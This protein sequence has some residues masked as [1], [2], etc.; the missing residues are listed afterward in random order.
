MN[1]QHVE[2]GFHYSAKELKAVATKI[3]KLATYCNKVKDESSYIRVDAEN[4]KTE[5]KRDAMKVAMTIKLPSKILRA[6]SRRPE[7][8]EAIDRCVEKLTTQVKKY[9]ELH[10][11]KGKAQKTRKHS[12]K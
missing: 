11:A 10:T 9:K 4:R 2:K 7:V 12:K 3:G 8:T 6:E 5:K 1:I